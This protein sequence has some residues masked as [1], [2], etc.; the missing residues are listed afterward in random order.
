VGANLA[1]PL[2]WINHRARETG[3]RCRRPCGGRDC[4][5]DL[6]VENVDRPRSDQQRRSVLPAG[7]PSTSSTGHPRGACRDKAQRRGPASGRDSRVL[8]PRPSDT[9]HC[10]RLVTRSLVRSGRRP[11]HLGATSACSFRAPFRTGIPP[12]RA[13]IWRQIPPRPPD[14]D[15]HPTLLR[16]WLAVADRSGHSAAESG[17]SEVTGAEGS[18]SAWRRRNTCRSSPKYLPVSR[19]VPCR[20]AAPSPRHGCCPAGRPRRSRRCRGWA[21]SSPTPGWSRR[22]SRIPTPADRDEPGHRGHISTSSRGICGTGTVSKP[23]ACHRAQRHQARLDDEHH[24]R[25]RTQNGPGISSIRTATTGTSCTN[26]RPRC[27][28]HQ[29]RQVMSCSTHS[30]WAAGSGPPRA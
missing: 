26:D 22:R 5:V 19:P 21:P 29:L 24:R 6:S 23:A 2:F 9:A 20:C 3:D 15:G 28:S 10:A 4:G 18:K 11:R 1:Y 7:V 14:L 17:G 30:R 25:P 27:R 12:W 16:P 13:W 8:T